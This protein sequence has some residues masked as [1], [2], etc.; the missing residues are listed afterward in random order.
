MGIYKDIEA[1][2]VG[3]QGLPA[4]YRRAFN[5]VTCSGGL[6]TNLLPKSCFED[7]LNALTPNGHCVFTVSQKHLK[8]DSAFKMGY[9]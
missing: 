5:I 1:F 2:I 9:L 7:M 4:S 6:G 3:K 8:T